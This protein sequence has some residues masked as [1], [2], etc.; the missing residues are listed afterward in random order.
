MLTAAQLKDAVSSYYTKRRYCIHFE[1]GL[2]RRG[3]LRADV[4]ALSMSGQLIIVETKSSKRDYTSDRKWQNYRPYANKLYLAFDE[5]VFDEVAHLV[6]AD[7]GVL[8]VRD[9]I[10]PSGRTR[11]VVAV[12]QRARSHEVDVEI[13]FNMIVRMAFKSSDRNRFKK[14]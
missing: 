4:V 2:N 3:K 10:Y 11:K 13:Q 14:R 1:V 7:V 9:R 5:E 6:P 8:V 12:E